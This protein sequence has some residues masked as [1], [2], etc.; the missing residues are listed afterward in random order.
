MYENVRGGIMEIQKDDSLYVH[1]AKK[2]T[3]A[4]LMSAFALQIVSIFVTT[5]TGTMLLS[6]DMSNVEVTATTTLGFLREHFEFEYLTSR[7]SFLQGILNWLAGVALEHTIPR[8]GEGKAAINM[9]RFVAISLSTLV[10]LLLSF[11]NAHMTFYHNYFHMLST[12]SQVAANRFFGHWRLRPMMFLY[13]PG[14]IGSI[15]TGMKAMTNCE[16]SEER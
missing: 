1:V 6:K 4:L 16:Y 10:I 15:Y 12:W 8:K 14:L 2:L 9:N 13:V 11:Y 5:V 7:L 3:S